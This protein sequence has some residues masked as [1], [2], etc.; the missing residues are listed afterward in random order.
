MRE[1]TLENACVRVGYADFL[2]DP[3]RVFRMAED[4]GTVLLTKDDGSVAASI[5]MPTDEREPYSY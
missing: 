3:E 2:K 1:D 5:S 4:S